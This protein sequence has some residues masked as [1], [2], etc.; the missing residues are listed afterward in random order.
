M[1]SIEQ[2]ARLTHDPWEDVIECHLSRLPDKTKDGRDTIKEGYAVGINENG[3][4]EWRVAVSYLLGEDVLGISV[5][6]Q[7]NA[8]TKHLADVMR[9]LGWSSGK[10]NP[11]NETLSRLHKTN[12]GKNNRRTQGSNPSSRRAEACNR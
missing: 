4:R 12:R 8:T 11:H 3:E 7:T 5:D 6:R 10:N 9:T 1:A 2:L